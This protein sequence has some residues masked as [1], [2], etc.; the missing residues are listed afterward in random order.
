MYPL[1]ACFVSAWLTPDSADSQHSPRSPSLA[2][3]STIKIQGIRNEMVLHKVNAQRQKDAIPNDKSSYKSIVLRRMSAAAIS[4]TSPRPIDRAPLVQLSRLPRCTTRMAEIP[5]APFV[6]TCSHLKPPEIRVVSLPKLTM[7]HLQGMD[8]FGWLRACVGR[9][10][11]G[12]SRFKAW[13]L[14]DN[15]GS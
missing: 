5:W 1:G 7:Y 13:K 14:E 8:G 4:G 3:P 2:D 12:C 9:T 6:G 10:Y 15:R 11:P